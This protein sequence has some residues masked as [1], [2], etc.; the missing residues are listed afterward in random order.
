[1]ILRIRSYNPYRALLHNVTIFIIFCSEHLHVFRLSFWVLVII[2][3][4]CISYLDTR[5]PLFLFPLHAI[6]QWVR[7][8]VQFLAQKE[9]LLVLS[10]LLS[11]STG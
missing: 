7:I 1:M 8:R 9:V 10:G 2:S 5:V 11:V 4:C 3:F 6:Q